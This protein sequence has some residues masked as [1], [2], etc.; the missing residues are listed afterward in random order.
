MIIIIVQATAYSPDSIL[1]A[2]PKWFTHKILSRVIDFWMNKL[3]FT[4]WLIY[5]IAAWS[6]EAL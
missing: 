6:E 5:L 2:A 1:H 4:P 3:L